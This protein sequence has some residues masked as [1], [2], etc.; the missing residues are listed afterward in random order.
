[1]NTVKQAIHTVNDYFFDDAE[2]MPISQALWY[3]VPMLLMVVVGI[4]IG[5]AWVF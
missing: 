1:M 3:Y 4:S 5:I 2:D